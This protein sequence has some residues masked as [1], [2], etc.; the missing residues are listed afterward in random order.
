M[1]NYFNVGLK[2]PYALMGNIL[3]TP[4]QEGLAGFTHRLSR[5]ADYDTVIVINMKVKW[6]LLKWCISFANDNV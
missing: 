1:G 2:P 3:A 4:V 5:C 6:K